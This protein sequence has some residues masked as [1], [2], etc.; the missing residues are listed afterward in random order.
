MMHAVM[1]DQQ[2]H[3]RPWNLVKGTNNT[4]LEERKRGFTVHALY[5]DGEATANGEPES[6]PNA[7][8]PK[9]PPKTATCDMRASSM[10]HESRRSE[11]MH[12]NTSTT[13]NDKFLFL[14]SVLVG[15]WTEEIITKCGVSRH[16]INRSKVHIC[17]SLRPEITCAGEGDFKLL[18]NLQKI[19]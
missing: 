11:V 1:C 9:C 10:V 8:Q 12:M 18:T 15:A 7:D 19:P 16:E 14:T 2:R 13:C 17:Y 5:V 6:L 4:M 3:Y